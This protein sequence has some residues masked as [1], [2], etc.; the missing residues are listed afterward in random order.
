MLNNRN[1][2]YRERIFPGGTFFLC[3]IKNLQLC[4]SMSYNTVIVLL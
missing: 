3:G 1:V 4:R 2:P